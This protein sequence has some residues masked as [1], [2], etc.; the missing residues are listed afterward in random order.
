MR[1]ETLRFIVFI[2][3]LFIASTLQFLSVSIFGIIPN[4]VLAT[5]VAATLFLG[6]VWH[7]LFL[8]SVA[9]FL[10]K[11]SPVIEREM[12]ALFAV[13]LLVIVL[14]RR[15]PW[16]MFINGIFL[17]VFSVASL[18]ILIDVRSITSLM[19][20]QELVYTLVLVSVI[21]YGLTSLRLFRNTR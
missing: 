13:M 4:F 15:L 3:I 8:I 20:A 2:A 11:F 17:T 5:I 12:L 9:L 19:F 14:E 21:Y 10:L 16:H 18:Y 1:K 6:D 7:E